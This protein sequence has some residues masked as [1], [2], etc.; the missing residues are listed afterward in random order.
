MPGTC[1]LEHTTPDTIMKSDELIRIAI[2]VA[3]IAFGVSAYMLLV[4][5]QTAVA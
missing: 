4:A 5:V 3:T 1:L 2:A